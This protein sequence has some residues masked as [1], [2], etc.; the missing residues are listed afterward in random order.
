ML[1]DRTSMTS[2]TTNS[3]NL[4]REAQSLRARGSI[5][6]GLSLL[7]SVLSSAEFDNLFEEQV[8]LE[9]QNK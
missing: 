2:S 8:K 6:S 5:K 7:E 9:L 3:A 1:K 4:I